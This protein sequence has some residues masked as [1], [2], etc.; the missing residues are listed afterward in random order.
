M[1]ACVGLAVRGVGLLCVVLAATTRGAMTTTFAAVET[2]SFLGPVCL[3][4]H[5]DV[6]DIYANFTS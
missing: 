3:Y 5:S 6:R 4:F 2:A 1:W